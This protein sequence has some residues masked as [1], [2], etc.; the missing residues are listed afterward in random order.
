[1]QKTNDQIFSKGTNIAEPKKPG[2]HKSPYS[3]LDAA[4]DEI[5][6]KHRSILNSF[7]ELA[8]ILDT[9]KQYII[10]DGPLNAL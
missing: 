5:D 7:G 3:M 10:N 1:M 9:V 2:L 4:N 8:K 6:R